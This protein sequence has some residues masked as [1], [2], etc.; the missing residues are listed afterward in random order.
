MNFGKTVITDMQIKYN[1][2]GMEI[3]SIYI[4]AIVMNNQIDTNVKTESLETVTVS[5]R[6]AG[7]DTLKYYIDKLNKI[8]ER[9]PTFYRITIEHH[10]S[11]LDHLMNICY[12][13][14][15]M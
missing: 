1:K 3:K 8:T 9:V 13:N 5:L 4:E 15:N 6:T 2:I 12:E 11:I 10:E 7:T 14:L